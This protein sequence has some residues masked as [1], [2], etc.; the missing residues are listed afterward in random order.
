VRRASI[1][2]CNGE[3]SPVSFFL[4]SL[5]ARFEGG[6]K[7]EKNKEKIKKKV[8]GGSFVKSLKVFNL[9]IMRGGEKKEE[10]R[11]RGRKRRNLFYIH[12]LLKY[13]HSERDE[14]KRER[15]EREEG[16][17]GGCTTPEGSQLMSLISTAGIYLN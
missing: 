10:K 7:E 3:V 9:R 11:R 14:G 12:D 6:G 4:I 8:E 2:F 15:G 16:K 5:P 17:I 13:C 1:Y